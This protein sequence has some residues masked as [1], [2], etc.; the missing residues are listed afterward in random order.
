MYTKGYTILVMATQE[1]IYSMLPNVVTLG[2]LFL[3][4][5][6]ALF[7]PTLGAACLPT[8]GAA[9][10]PTLGARRNIAQSQIQAS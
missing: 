7:F 1:M 3:P 9:C 4:T 5:L 8:L 2:A 10:L 6:G